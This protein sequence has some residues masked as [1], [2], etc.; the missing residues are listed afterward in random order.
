MNKDRNGKIF[1]S[2]I[3]AR[4]YPFYGVQWHPE[5]SDDMNEFVIFFKNEVE[6][7]GHSEIFNFNDKLFTKKINCM[8]YSN[9]IYNYCNFYWHNLTSSHN[10]KLCNKLNLGKTT[11]NRV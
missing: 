11:S 4:N 3:E 8:I 5:R 1:I 2:T 6:K 7:N 9:N 10:K